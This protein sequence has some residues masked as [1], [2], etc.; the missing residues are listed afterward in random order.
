MQL[1]LSANWVI[2]TV[3]PVQFHHPDETSRADGRLLIYLECQ[4]WHRISWNNIPV[5]EIKK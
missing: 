4:R 1:A 3:L 2:T 5:E